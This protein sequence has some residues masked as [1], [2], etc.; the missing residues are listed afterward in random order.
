MKRIRSFLMSEASK[1]WVIRD[2]LALACTYI[3]LYFQRKGVC[4]IEDFQSFAI[5]CLILAMKMEEGKFPTISFSVFSKEELLAWEKKVAKR[6]S[7]QLSPPTY[8]TFA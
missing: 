7:Y 3:D 4:E 6:L 5:S 8:V 2:T 1:Q